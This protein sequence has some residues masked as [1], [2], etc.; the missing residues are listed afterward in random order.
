MVRHEIEHLAHF[1]FVQFRNP[2]LVIVLRTD[3]GVEF[4]M[5]RDV[6]AMQA[7]RP[8]LEIRRRITIANPERVEIR[9]NLARLIKGK[10]PVELQPVS[11]RRNARIL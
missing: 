9:H 5:I 7:L 3:R 4:V 11:R 1:V 10:F 6:V 2:P 8:G